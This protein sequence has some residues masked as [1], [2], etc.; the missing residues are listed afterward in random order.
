MNVL[1]TGASSGIGKALVEQ[2]AQQGATH[3]YAAARRVNEL[4]A[5]ARR[6]E[7]VTAVPFDAANLAA[8]PAFVHDMVHAKEI[9][10]FVVNAG[11]QRGFDFTKVRRRDNLHC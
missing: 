7:N 9:D 6:Y 10:H 1:I 3:V 4:E 2:Y 5:L 11:V 8:L